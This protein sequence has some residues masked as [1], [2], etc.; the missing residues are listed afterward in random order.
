MSTFQMR[1]QRLREGS[2]LAQ[3]SKKLGSGRLLHFGRFLR[4]NRQGCQPYQEVGEV[5]ASEG[6][7][8]EL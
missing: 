3:A 6:R 5:C 7:R 2:D 8:W 1:K 4:G